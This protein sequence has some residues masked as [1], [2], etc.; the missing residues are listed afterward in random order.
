MAYLLSVLRHGFWKALEDHIGV[1]Y[2]TQVGLAQRKNSTC[3][4]VYYCSSPACFFF[5]SIY[6]LVTFSFQCHKVDLDLFR[7]LHL[8]RH[9]SLGVVPRRISFWRN[10]GIQKVRVMDGSYKLLHEVLGPRDW[11]QKPFEKHFQNCTFGWLHEYAQIY[12]L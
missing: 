12:S 2:W 4:T 9:I 8:L 7:D 10:M 1:E 11:A 6:T 5:W 3:P